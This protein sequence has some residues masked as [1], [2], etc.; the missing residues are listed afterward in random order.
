MTPLEKIITITNAHFET[1]VMQN[2]KK[3]WIVDGR[4]VCYKILHD[5]GFSLIK[6]GRMFG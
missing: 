5:D 4:A 6:I 2:T 3:R 1:D